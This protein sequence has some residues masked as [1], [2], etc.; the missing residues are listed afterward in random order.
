MKAVKKITCPNCGRELPNLWLVA[1]GCKWCIKER[2]APTLSKE[3]VVG[4]LRAIEKAK[5]I[6][7]ED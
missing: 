3:I 4:F 1:G 7:K 5:G 6:Y 2:M